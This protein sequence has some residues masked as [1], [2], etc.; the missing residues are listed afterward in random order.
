MDNV[1]KQLLKKVGRRVAG[2]WGPP[3]KKLK[4]AAAKAARRFLKENT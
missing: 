2:T 1:M 3:R 4:R